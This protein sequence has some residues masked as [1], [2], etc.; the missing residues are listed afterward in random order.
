[1]Y[2]CI[3]IYQMWVVILT[4]FFFSSICS[5]GFS[6]LNVI[7]GCGQGSDG[8]KPTGMLPRATICD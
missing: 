7:S 5:G 8:Q 2:V 6:F 4:V 1:M 3:F